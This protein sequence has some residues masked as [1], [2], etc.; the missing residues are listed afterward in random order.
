MAGEEQLHAV[1]VPSKA[2]Q[3]T[4]MQLCSLSRT[5]EGMRTTV[6]V[7]LP[8]GTF[9]LQSYVQDGKS[10]HTFCR[11]LT[12][13]LKHIQMHIF[14]IQQMDAVMSCFFFCLRG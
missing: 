3:R 1:T 4:A 5:Q 10:A 9:N 8:V 11:Y 7:S 13:T 2:C 6:K 14:N 12:H